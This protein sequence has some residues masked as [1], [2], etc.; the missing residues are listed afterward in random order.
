MAATRDSF[1]GHGTVGSPQGSI[2]EQIY[3]LQVSAN[4]AAIAQETPPVYVP[5]PKHR[6]GHN[7]G[8]ENPIKTLEEG[9]YLLETGYPDGKQIYNVTADGKLVKFQPDNSPEN[10]YH[11]YEVL[12]PPD[13]PP[14]VLRRMLQDGKISKSDYK[15]FLKGKK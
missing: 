2:E 8:T 11:A 7:W 4:E 10:G 14:G 3:P 6:P 13:I 1:L 5:S 12:G 9:Q 15:K